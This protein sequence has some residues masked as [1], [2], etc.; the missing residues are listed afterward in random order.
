[1]SDSGVRHKDGIMR[2]T[3]SGQQRQT[4]CAERDSGEVSDSGVRHKDGQ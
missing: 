3:R 1:V 2:C 4:P